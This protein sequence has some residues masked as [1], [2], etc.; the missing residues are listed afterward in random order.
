MAF[1][2]VAGLY[3]GAVH[4]CNG[5]SEYSITELK[6]FREMLSKPDA[7]PLDRLFAFEQMACSDRPSI[8]SYALKVG[9]NTITDPLVRNEIML[10]ALMQKKRIDVEL[11]SS[12]N[13]TDDDKKFIAE[14]AG[15]YSRNVTFQSEPDG[16][17][18][19]YGGSCDVAYSL[20]IMGDKVELNYSQVLGQFRLS[21]SG[22]LVGT[23]R[24]G[25]GAKFTQIP[26]VIK[27]Y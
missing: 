6:E 16:C 26:A 11:G 5:F 9:L 13:Q 17:V 19:L 25:Q 10:K 14:H 1:V 18:S 27:L 7:D 22:E 4:A 3:S 12:K 15:V 23:L 24:A 21:S 20:F 8:R 2:C